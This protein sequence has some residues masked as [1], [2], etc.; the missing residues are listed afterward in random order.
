MM[1]MMMGEQ[2][3]RNLFLAFS[4]FEQRLLAIYMQSTMN[5]IKCVGLKQMSCATWLT[6]AE[7][8][9]QAQRFSEIDKIKKTT[10]A[11]VSKSHKAKK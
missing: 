6:F 9:T 2:K 8:V 7:N 11:T 4:F 10:N 5:T 3:I 1:M